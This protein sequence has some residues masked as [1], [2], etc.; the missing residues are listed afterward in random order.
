M[1]YDI[2]DGPKTTWV[3]VEPDI[4]TFY[5]DEPPPASTPVQPQFNGFA[6]KFINMS[7]RSV[8]LFWIDGSKKHPMRHHGPFIASG[9]ATF[10]GHHFAFTE[11]DQPDKV[12]KSFLVGSYPSSLYWYDPYFVE[13]DP[14]ATERNLNELNADERAKYD[15]WRR[16][17]LFH[18]QYLNITGRAYLANY[19]RERPMH[20]MWRADHFGQTHWVETRETHF[21]VE[22]PP[23]KL[24]P[25]I[26]LP[27]S[28]VLGRDDPRILQEY[29][30]EGTKT[31][32]MTLKVSQ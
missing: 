4:T 31:K 11:N 24:G 8:T 5:E 22:P 28:R 17:L 3:Y 23:D 15:N 20:H 26:G 12:L 18:E 9:T 1:E 16:T 7:N 2:G 32:N 6:G 25:V 19:L 30:E 27:K 21:V 10:P 13:N 14:E 29:R